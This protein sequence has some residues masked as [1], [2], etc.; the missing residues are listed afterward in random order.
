MMNPCF[1]MLVKDHSHALELVMSTALS[2]G[3]TNLTFTLQTCLWNMKELM[4]FFFLLLLNS[5]EKQVYWSP[6]RLSLNLR[7]LCLHYV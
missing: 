3:Q 6:D 5:H 4:S 2:L 1:F 7:L